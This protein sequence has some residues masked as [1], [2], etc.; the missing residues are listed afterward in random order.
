MTYYIVLNSDLLNFSPMWINRV[1][2][3]QKWLR[4]FLCTGWGCSGLKLFGVTGC[5]TS[6]DVNFLIFIRSATCEWNQAWE[7]NKNRSYS[8]GY[9][10]LAKCTNQRKNFWKFTL[11]ISSVLSS[12]TS[13]TSSYT[14]FQVQKNL[15]L[16]D[17]NEPLLHHICS[18]DIKKR[19]VENSHNHCLI[20]PNLCKQEANFYQPIT[21]ACFFFPVFCHI[22]QRILIHRRRQA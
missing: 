4:Q 21:S 2:F 13:I 7:R 5:W 1:S 11:L 14:S 3:G 15:I 18:S 20:T 12:L 19:T 17:H 16:S 9:T 8:L 22:S 6:L 10:K